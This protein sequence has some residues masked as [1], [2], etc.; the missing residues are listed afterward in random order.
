MKNIFKAIVLFSSL[1][2]SSCANP[3][4]LQAI[5]KEINAIMEFSGFRSAS[6]VSGATSSTVT[7]N[8]YKVSTTIGD[9][10]QGSTVSTASGYRVSSFVTSQ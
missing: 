4:D 6:M 8:G 2:L 1:S 5:E 3:F 7:N 10:A 9:L